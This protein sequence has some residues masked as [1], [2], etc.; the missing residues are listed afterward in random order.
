MGILAKLGSGAIF[1]AIKGFGGIATD[2]RKMRLDAEVAMAETKSA[3]RREE[4]KADIE[5]L[6]RLV[7]LSEQ[8]GEHMRSM[9]QEWWM[10]LPMLGI[11]A[12]AFLWVASVTMRS[13]YNY[14]APIDLDPAMVEILKTVIYSMFGVAGL[15]M[16]VNRLR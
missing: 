13:L 6:D 8:A 12:C 10:K 4:L 5:R 9:M 2:L 7:T 14:G 3:E 11:M 16:G 1:G 15:L